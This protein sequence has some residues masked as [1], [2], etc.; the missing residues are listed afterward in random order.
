MRPLRSVGLPGPSFVVPFLGL[1]WVLVRIYG[2]EPSKGATS[3]G[4]GRE[5]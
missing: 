3:R 2:M 1:G 4:S 5:L